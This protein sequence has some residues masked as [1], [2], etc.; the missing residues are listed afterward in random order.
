MEYITDT[1]GTAA[2]ETIGKHITEFI[3]WLKELISWE[4]LF[5]AV[6]AFFV[7][8]LMWIVYKL[9]VH[10]LKK[11]SPK[12]L[13]E[14]R[15]AAVIRGI[16]YF[17]YVVVV[18]YILSTF[19]VNL[20]A[21]WGAAGIAGVAIGFAAQTSMSNLISG[22]FVL[23]EGA[24]HIGDVIIIDGV[25]GIVDEVKLLSVRMHTFDN[26]MVR[27]PNSTIIN[28]NLTNNS[29]HKARRITISVSI[30]YSTD[31]NKALEV[32]SKA[33]SLC[34]TVLTNPAPTV[35]FDGFEDSGINMTVAACF[36]P[37]DFL[38]TKNDLFVSIKK[39][40][41]D[42]GIEIPFNQLDVKIKNSDND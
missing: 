11:I 1:V 9:I 3:N 36:K 32:L 23:T 16:K 37:S 35:W 22:L 30:D 17:F 18:L 10:S 38:K 28:N 24:I 41:D 12:K 34:P 14:A 13:P 33:P 40:F 26:Q 8:L 4:N 29:Y 39:V 27:I 7:I 31:M 25:T 21:I 5:K 6:G 42:N 20:K 19:G 2:N 15:V